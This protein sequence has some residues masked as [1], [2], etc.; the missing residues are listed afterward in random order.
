[1]A[2]AA[3][4]HGV[5]QGI[6]LGSAAH[7]SRASHATS[8]VQLKEDVQ[9]V[10]AQRDKTVGNAIRGAMVTQTPVLQQAI[11]AYTTNPLMS[12]AQND[13]DKRVFATLLPPADTASAE[14]GASR[15][16][17]T[18]EQQRAFNPPRGTTTSLHTPP[19]TKP[20]QHSHVLGEPQKQPSPPH[21][22]PPGQQPPI[23]DLF[24]AA[25]S[26]AA[27][28]KGMGKTAAAAALLR[29]AAKTETT[30]LQPSL[31]PPQITDIRRI[32]S[33][34]TNVETILQ[35]AITEY[36]RCMNDK[37][38]SRNLELL[39][40]MLGKHLIILAGIG[41][42]RPSEDNVPAVKKR[43]YYLFARLDA[44]RERCGSMYG[45]CVEATLGFEQTVSSMFPNTYFTVKSPSGESTELP[46]GIV[47]K[48]T[49]EV[50][51]LLAS[52]T[53]AN[54][55]FWCTNGAS[56]NQ[57]LVCRQIQGPD[58]PVRF[59]TVGIQNGSFD[60]QTSAMLYDT[61]EEDGQLIG[62]QRAVPLPGASS[63]TH[64]R[65]AHG[66]HPPSAAKH[67]KSATAD[68]PGIAMQLASVFGA[69][70]GK[71]RAAKKK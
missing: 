47:C 49:L 33:A 20:E 16:A 42:H 26:V 62:D 63:Q 35:Y 58:I 17:I 41:M 38:R 31:P 39:P 52:A 55:V 9:A 36:G 60:K 50:F 13:E 23:V 65:T 68:A 25:A 28:A 10:Q 5:A 67:G 30:S 66:P 27:A 19:N 71:R 2:V 29:H 21:Q 3:V 14:P 61:L 51:G 7:A 57:L 15:P 34:L 54:R 37:D 12:A 45:V 69:G 44:F 56:G 43:M 24:G 22:P 53:K 59:F 4:A 11:G 48:T 40:Q 46:L 70:G 6:G 8:L 18:E 64:K 1:M 32:N